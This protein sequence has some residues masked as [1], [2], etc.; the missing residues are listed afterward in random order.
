VN[1]VAVSTKAYK[2]ILLTPNFGNK[3]K[4]LDIDALYVIS[5]S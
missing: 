1:P 2:Y 4:V 5:G 3:L